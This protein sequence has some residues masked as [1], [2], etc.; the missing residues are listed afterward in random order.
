MQW[1][2]VDRNGIIQ[3]VI[4]YD[5]VSPYTPAEGL[6]LQQVNIWLGRGNNINDPE[7]QS[8]PSPSPQP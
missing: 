4:A 7:P 8:P 6:T 3:N 1:A 5:G 2:L